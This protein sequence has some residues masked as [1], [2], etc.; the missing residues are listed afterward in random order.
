MFDELSEKS[1]S[2]LYTIV[3]ISFVLS[4]MIHLFKYVN[5]TSTVKL[6]QHALKDRLLRKNDHAAISLTLSMIL[7]RLFISLNQ[8]SNHALWL[9]V[10]LCCGRKNA[11]CV[12]VCVWQWRQYICIY[13]KAMWYLLSLA[14]SFARFHYMSMCSKREREK[15]FFSLTEECRYFICSCYIIV[16]FVDAIRVD[17]VFFLFGYPMAYTPFSFVFFFAIMTDRS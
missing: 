17:A 4:I 16:V 8:R 5:T 13:C 2:S 15:E 14:R 1:R 6:H 3:Q 12:V 10:G 7:N 11:R 9:L